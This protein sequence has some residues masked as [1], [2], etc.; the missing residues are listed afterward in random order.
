MTT[1]R[2]L[3]AVE[4]ERVRQ[5]EKWGGPSHDDQ[6]TS[7]D[8]VAWIVRYTGRSVT[9]GAFDTLRF[10]SHMVKVAA[11]AIAAIEWADRLIEKGE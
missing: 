3:E 11:L 9:Y 4:A 6:H 2:V 5:D 7:H 10:R 8:W 1:S